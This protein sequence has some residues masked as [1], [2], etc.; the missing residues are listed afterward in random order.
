MQAVTP[1]SFVTPDGVERVLRSTYGAR[2]RLADRFGAG[3]SLQGILN[4]HGE[5][6]LPAILYSLLF[7]EKGKPPDVTLE[8]LEEMLPPQALPEIMAAILACLSQGEV[9][10]NDLEA[11]MK[12]ALEEHQTERVRELTGSGSGVS[13]PPISASDSQTNNSGGATPRMKSKRSS[14]ASKSGRSSKISALA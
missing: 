5:T 8:E 10:K 2:K 1:V 3:K 12:R 9:E 4:E 6:A 11:L 14:T 13:V 7:D